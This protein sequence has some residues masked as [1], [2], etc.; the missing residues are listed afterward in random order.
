MIRS[1]IKPAICWVHVNKTPYYTHV[2]FLLVSVVCLFVCFF[3]LGRIE[4][5][6]VDRCISVSGYGRRA[7]HGC[8]HWK[9]RSRWIGKSLG[10]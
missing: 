8:G 1:I 9:R 2:C 4:S 5:R 3:L 10:D 7:H 6:G